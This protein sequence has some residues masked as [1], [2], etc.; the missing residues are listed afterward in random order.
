MEFRLVLFCRKHSGCRLN[1]AVT[2]SV[3]NPLSFNCPIA[4]VYLAFVAGVYL[5]IF[6]NLWECPLRKECLS[7]G[8]PA[9]YASSGGVRKNLLSTRSFV[10]Q[11]GRRKVSCDRIGAL[12][13]IFHP[14]HFGGMEASTACYFA[15][16]LLFDRLFPNLNTLAHKLFVVKQQMLLQSDISLLRAASLNVM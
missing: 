9:L 6:D 4:S 11:S 16:A 3:S 7:V 15:F 8:I 13:H 10:P 2:L 1:P 5:L 14:C 12:Q